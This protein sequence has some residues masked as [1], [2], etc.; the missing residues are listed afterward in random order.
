MLNRS[1]DD[2]PKP[3]HVIVVGNEKGGSGKST[4]AVHVV[5][6]LARAGHRVATI[7][8]DSHNKTLTHFIEDRCNWA[9]RSGVALEIPDSFCLTEAEGFRRDDNERADRDALIKVVA[10]VEHSYDF[11]VIDTPS[12]D[13]YLTW[14]ALGIADTLITPL[15]D[16]FVDFDALGN[17]DPVTYAL[18]EPSKYAKMVRDERRARRQF[19]HSDI[20]WV[21]MRNRLSTLH[22]RS[23]DRLTQAL[24]DLGL[25][26][27]FRCAR[28]FTERAIY[29]DL[30]P[31]GLTVLDAI[32]E[33][34]LG[35]RHIQSHRNAREEVQALIATLKLPIDEKARR[36]AAARSEWFAARD[37][38]LKLDEIVQ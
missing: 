34:A 2:A 11:L 31:R 38:G 24:S 22:S 9:K 33:P 7:D 6:A 16:S 27:G 15:N 17:I 5:V 37:T 25:Q 1:G 20:D 32:D 30:F 23:T 10:S 4:I 35:K 3:A 28:G 36:H 14:L 8:L 13:G 12:A 19:D 26:L 29:R 18:I 21:V